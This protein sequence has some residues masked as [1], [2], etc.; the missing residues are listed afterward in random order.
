M[1]SI[2]MKM[3]YKYTTMRLP[4]IFVDDYMLDCLPVYPLIYIWSMRRLIDGKSAT[5]QEIGERF[6][7]TEGDVIKAWQ[8]LE[9]EKLVSITSGKDG[10]EITFLPVN[11]RKKETS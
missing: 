2:K 1:N 9:K 4:F 3:G 10:M 6:S 7:L 11:E 5:F 8:H